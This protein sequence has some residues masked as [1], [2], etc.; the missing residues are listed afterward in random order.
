MQVVRDLRRCQ[1]AVR[2]H[3]RSRLPEALDTGGIDRACKL[4]ESDFLCPVHQRADQLFGFTAPSR[5]PQPFA[6]LPFDLAHGHGRGFLGPQAGQSEYFRWLRGQFQDVQPETFDEGLRNGFSQ[7][8][9]FW[10]RLGPIRA[11]ANEDSV[12]VGELQLIEM[13]GLELHIAS[14][15]ESVDFRHT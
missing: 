7:P 3:V 10:D 11:P 4:L 5:F 6:G 8:C 12:A 2:P 13:I 1:I 9:K 15:H 14:P